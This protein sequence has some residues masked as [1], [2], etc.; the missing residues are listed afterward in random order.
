L[1]A[2]RILGQRL[3]ALGALL[4]VERHQRGQ[5]DAARVVQRLGEVDGFG[6]RAGHGLAVDGA[7]QL[8]ARPL[9]RSSGRRCSFEGWS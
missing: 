8:P 3:Q 2:A 7:A 1:F 4:E 5:A 6:V 9:C